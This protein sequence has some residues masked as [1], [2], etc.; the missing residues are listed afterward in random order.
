MHCRGME[1]SRQLCWSPL[2]P[3]CKAAGQEVEESRGSCRDSNGLGAV[4]EHHMAPS[5]IA[6]LKTFP[7]PM[8]IAL[9]L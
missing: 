4:P 6:V 5:A 2:L 8:L 7:C 9:A 1:K 3:P